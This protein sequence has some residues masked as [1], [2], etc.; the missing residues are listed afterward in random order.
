MT[1]ATFDGSVAKYL[2]VL[3]SH[4][5][6]AGRVFFY[7]VENKSDSHPFAFL[8]TYSRDAGGNKA[9]HVALKN[10]LQEYH[11]DQQLLLQLLSTV[12]RAAGV[13]GFI[14]E[15]VESGE[16]FSPLR[17]TQEEA[18]VF[19][20]EIA[21]YEACGIMCRIPDWWRKNPTR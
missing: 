11:D 7:L 12:S 15:L 17:F 4:I 5:D 9:E 14:A 10:A 8:A 13:S 21:L 19:L 1:L 2:L 18:Y 6:V 16:L 3:D 20:K